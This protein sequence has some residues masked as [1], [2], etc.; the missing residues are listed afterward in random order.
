MAQDIRSKGFRIEDISSGKVRI[1]GDDSRGL[2]YGA[3]EFLRS[4][5]YHQG[6]F[7]LRRW[8]A[9]SP[10]LPVTLRLRTS[11]GTGTK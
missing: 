8:R 7:T 3:G 9:A 6:S 4:N 5:A 2:L 1:I 10:C 11:K